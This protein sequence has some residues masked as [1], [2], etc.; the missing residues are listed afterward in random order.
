M[1]PQAAEV[2]SP[3][4]KDPLGLLQVQETSAPKFGFVAFRLRGPSAAAAAFL[5]QALLLLAMAMLQAAMLIDW[6]RYE[7]T[8][9]MIERSCQS[10]WVYLCRCAPAE[11]AMLVV[12]IAIMVGIRFGGGYTPVMVGGYALVWGKLVCGQLEVGQPRTWCLLQVM[13]HLNLVIM[14]LLYVVVG[15]EASSTSFIDQAFPSLK[16]QVSYFAV[17]CPHLALAGTAWLERIRIAQVSSNEFTERARADTQDSVDTSSSIGT[18]RL[19][20]ARPRSL[21]LRAV[22]RFKDAVVDKLR[23]WTDELICIFVLVL[24][25]AAALIPATDI[26]S[27]LLLFGTGPAL[28]LYNTR[29]TNRSRKLDC[30]YFLL[31]FSTALMFVFRVVSACAL[32]PWPEDDDW[33]IS[34]QELGV[35]RPLKE[36]PMKVALLGVI[37]IFSRLAIIA[38]MRV[39]R[40]EAERREELSVVEE[41]IKEESE[42]AEDDK[43][44][45]FQTAEVQKTRS[46]G[47]LPISEMEA[48]IPPEHKSFDSQPLCEEIKLNIEDPKLEEQHEEQQRHEKS[49]GSRSVRFAPK[50][51]S[52]TYE[53]PSLEPVKRRRHKRT[54]L[55][56]PRMEERFL[57]YVVPS[58][59]EF[60][61]L[62]AHVYL[63]ALLLVLVFGLSIH[64]VNLLSFLM[65]LSVIC[66]CGWS[67][68]WVQAG[69]VFSFATLTILWLQY[70]ARF[71]FFANISSD[72]VWL[73]GLG[74]EWTSSEV[75]KHCVILAVCILQKQY[76]Y[77]GRFSKARPVVCPSFLADHADVAGFFGLI[78]VAVIRRHAL[79]SLLVLGGLPWV[80]REELPWK[81]S[82]QRKANTRRRMVPAS[83]LHHPHS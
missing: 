58:W 2:I 18:F 69:N 74:L 51:S 17:V 81:E 46:D 62:Q 66:L 20:P 35:V 48:N 82:K 80:I 5:P 12:M 56:G 63:S 70:L 1:D 49:H 72:S 65:M 43:K 44:E 59:M 57:T 19:T 39:Q 45:E 42:E 15:A 37:P 34:L 26:H 36:P 50:G 11:L 60:M 25:F 76:W 21:C 23:K 3:H 47:S 52:Q 79:S 78:A 38:I 16:H 6:A 61:P 77:R 64:Q 54:Q 13:G 68:R 29:G 71:R 8:R 31:R 4:V 24:A 41:A 67:H 75:E 10:T 27:L 30:G 14:T 32:I 7:E 9:T 33:P 73:R 83:A 22:L 53:V 55:P 40:E 28:L